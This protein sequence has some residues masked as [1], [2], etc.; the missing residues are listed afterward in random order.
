MGFSWRK[1]PIKFSAEKVPG[2]LNNSNSGG[3]RRRIHRSRT[4]FLAFFRVLEKRHSAGLQKKRK[5]SYF[6]RFFLW[7]NILI[8]IEIFIKIYEKYPVAEKIFSWFFSTKIKKKNIFF[9]FSSK[10]K[11]IYFF[12]FRKNK[13]KVYAIKLAQPKEL[14]PQNL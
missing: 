11:I 10:T 7:K 9:L 3:V 2:L 8:F 1:S 4:G 5:N 12:L 13:N 14:H 6:F